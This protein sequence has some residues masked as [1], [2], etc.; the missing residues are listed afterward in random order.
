VILG[1]HAC[2]TA[3]LTLEFKGIEYE[4]VTFPTGL[5]P[6]LVRLRGFPAGEVRELQGT[7]RTGNLKMADRLGT[8]P[9]L[10]FGDERVQ[11]N[12]AISRFLDRVRPD[13][14]LFP[15]DQG[16]RSQVEEAEAFGDQVLQM[17]ARRILMA[18]VHRGADTV[19]ERGSVGRLGPLLARSDRLREIETKFFGSRVFAATQDTEPE[20]L[21]ALPGQLDRVDSWVATGVLNGPQLNA[22]DFMIAPS[23]ALIGYRPDLRPELESRPLWALVDRL[24]PE[25]A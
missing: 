2:R 3:I 13:P 10:R 8:V 20:L 17:T 7:R 6:V 24:L 4:L 21:E 19:H 5:H 15:A 12:R 9:A 25:P 16:L 1:S 11:T 23:L 14:P 18:A 22:A